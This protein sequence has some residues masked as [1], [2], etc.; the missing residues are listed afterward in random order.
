LKAKSAIDKTT[1][2]ITPIICGGPKPA[3]WKKKTCDTRCRRRD[4]ENGVP[5]A[6]APTGD[7]FPKRRGASDDAG[8]TDENVQ[9]RGRLDRHADNHGEFLLNSSLT[10]ATIAEAQIDWSS[11]FKSERR[12]EGELGVWGR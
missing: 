3:E 8:E 6:E 11:A 12:S 2:E 1:I 4:E 10:G 5:E 7:H 9:E